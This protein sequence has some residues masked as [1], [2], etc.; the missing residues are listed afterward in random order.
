MPLLLYTALNDWRVPH[1]LII[2]LVTGSLPN[3]L[4]YGF[5][6][7]SAISLKGHPLFLPCLCCH[8][9]CVCVRV[10]VEPV[11]VSPL[12]CPY[13]SLRVLLLSLMDVGSWH[14]LPCSL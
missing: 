5:Y 7:V 2:T 11:N 6:Y 3:L 4:L 12:L 10:R 8:R 13:L 9:H 1:L 14:S